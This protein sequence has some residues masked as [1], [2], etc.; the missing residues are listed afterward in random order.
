[1]SELHLE[2]NRNLP[3]DSADIVIGRDQIVVPQRYAQLVGK[4]PNGG[5]RGFFKRVRDWTRSQPS[6]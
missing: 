4:T 2:G 1:M 6:E 5:D 3:I